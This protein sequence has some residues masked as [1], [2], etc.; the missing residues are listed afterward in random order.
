MNYCLLYVVLLRSEQE[1]RP[2]FIEAPGGQCKARLNGGRFKVPLSGERAWFRWCLHNWLEVVFTTEIDSQ[3]FAW[4]K[5]VIDDDEMKLSPVYDPV[6]FEFSFVDISLGR[7]V[8]ATLEATPVKYCGC[9][10]LNE[11]PDEEEDLEAADVQDQLDIDDYND[12][13]LEEQEEKEAEE[14]GGAVE[15][16]TRREIRRQFRPS[17]LIEYRYANLKHSMLRMLAAQG[18]P[19]HR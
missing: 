4:V 10:G 7:L 17:A 15:I 14:G 13:E 3:G 1:N 5:F 9:R 2:W 6:L 18:G 16:L 11:L 8:I 12:D 19:F